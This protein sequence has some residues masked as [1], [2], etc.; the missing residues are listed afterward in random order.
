M[1]K[2]PVRKIESTISAKAPSARFNIRDLKEILNGKDLI[3]DLHRHNFF[4]I[5]ALQHGEGKH[6]I[7]FESFDLADNIVFCLR[8]GQVHQL[9]LKSSCTG[10]L[11]EF[12]SEFYQPRDKISAQ[13]L[14][15]ATHKSFCQLEDSRF[16][17]LYA[18]LKNI[19]QE[20]RTQ[21]EGYQNIIRANLDILFIELVRQSRNPN[22]ESSSTISYAQER[23]E[24]FLDLLQANLS[25]SKQA[26]NYA[27]LM[28]VSSYQLNEITKTTMGKTASDLINEQ[29]ILEAKRNLLATSNLVK[30]I[31]ELLGYEDVSYFIRFFKKH[32]GFSPDAFRQN[33][34]Y[35][36]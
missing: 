12:D 25:T 7:D 9:K 29:I 20:Y 5:L 31:S 10:Y 17:K 6:E 21:E 32:T 36:L 22:A 14:R 34:K 27:E 3:Q 15:K 11:I 18:V 13:Q 4:F 30:E 8:P 35:V 23:L 19:S 26:S 28:N 33:F 1:K 2:I 16:E 24:E